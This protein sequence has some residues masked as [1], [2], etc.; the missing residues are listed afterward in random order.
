MEQQ[1]Y[2]LP[3]GWETKLI[4]EVLKLEYGKP[5]PKEDRDDEGA[6]PAYGAN[7]VKCRTN[8]YF[9]DKPSIIVGRKGSAGE[10]TLTEDKFWPLDVT[11]FVTFDEKRYDLIFLYYCLKSLKLTKLAKGVKP[12]INRNNV[13]QIDFSFPSLNEQKRIVAK[14]DALFTCIDTAIAHL[15]QALELSKALFASALDENFSSLSDRM[16]IGDIADVKGGKRLPK[17]NKLQQDL[18]ELPRGWEWSTLEEQTI[19]TKNIKP[20]SEPKQQFTYI[21]I[22][23]INRN[24]NQITNPKIIFGSEAPSRAKKEVFKNDVLFATTRPNLKNVA[25]FSGGVES[26]VASTGFCVLRA[27]ENIEPRYLFRFLTTEFLQQ[28]ISPLISGAQ[29][30]A[31]TDKNLKRTP[32]PLPPLNEQKRIVAKLDALSERTRALEA[33]TQEKLNDL[34]SLKAS[35]LDAAFKGQL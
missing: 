20:T 21:D 29:Y 19:S 11:Y 18:Y 17:G 13:Y 26:P 31:I 14:L 15:Q 4:G 34:T 32:I 33:A 2:E 22:S 24:I 27:A 7:G 30:P 3:E 12:G 28:Q 10:V 23:S 35:L 25:M 8:K 16:K 6:F 1:L 9:F 5:L